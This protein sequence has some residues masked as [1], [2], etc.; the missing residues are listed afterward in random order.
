M[1]AWPLTGTLGPLVTTFAVLLVALTQDTANILCEAQ[2]PTYDTVMPSA[3]PTTSIF[4]DDSF[5]RAQRLQR[6]III[7][8]AVSTSAV[9]C[10]PLVI[11]CCVRSLQRTSG[12]VNA[13]VGISS[14]EISTSGNNALR[15][16]GGIDQSS[17]GI[18]VHQSGG[19]IQVHR[20]GGGI[21]VHRS[22]GGIQVHQS[23]GG[24]PP[25]LRTRR[26]SMAGTG[27]GSIQ[28]MGILEAVHLPSRI[29]R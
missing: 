13:S 29:T 1:G 24:Y 9:F 16:N 12:D 7:A 8:I 22:G 23:G 28:H 4:D 2:G 21:Q 25:P 14:I 11:C 15:F 20:S 26:V 27:Q 3:S 5:E 6:T 10:I 18:Q 19:G 17:G